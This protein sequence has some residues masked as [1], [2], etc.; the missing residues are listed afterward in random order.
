MSIPE[1]PTA[2]V[3]AGLWYLFLYLLLDAIRH[4]RNLWFASLYLLITAY[5]AFVACPC[6]RNQVRDPRAWERPF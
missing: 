3:E 2:I 5:A 1:V 4:T 6:P